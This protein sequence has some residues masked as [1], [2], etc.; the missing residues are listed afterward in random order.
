MI[1]VFEPMTHKWTV[2]VPSEVDAAGGRVTLVTPAG[3]CSW[4][5]ALNSHTMGPDL[6]TVSV[7]RTLLCL[8]ENNIDA[9][10]VTFTS[11]RP[12]EVPQAVYTIQKDDKRVT[13]SSAFY[14]SPHADLRCT[15]RH[16]S[17]T[18]GKDIRR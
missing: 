6:L 7:S 15:W 16:R 2:I 17:V 5:R 11:E 12:Y 18:A 8:A 3:P 4:H 13:L 14:V 1:V 10:R 9:L